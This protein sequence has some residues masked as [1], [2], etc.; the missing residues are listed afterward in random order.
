MIRTELYCHPLNLDM[1]EL[2]QSQLS[3]HMSAPPNLH[4][5]HL[6]SQIGCLFALFTSNLW[7]WAGRSV[8]SKRL[9]SQFLM[10]IV[11][12]PWQPILIA[13]EDYFALRQSHSRSFT[14][15]W[16]LACICSYFSTSSITVGD[17]NLVPVN[18]GD[19]PN[20]WRTSSD[21]CTFRQTAEYKSQ[22]SLPTNGVI[23]QMKGN[24][25]ILLFGFMFGEYRQIHRWA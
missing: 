9:E 17:L 25:K 23:L 5:N 7:I 20:A 8:E 3:G 10:L 4:K 2:T 12:R 16:Q 6:R 13:F 22:E 11:L 15:S 1:N 24:E 18:S 14:G 21:V 19:I